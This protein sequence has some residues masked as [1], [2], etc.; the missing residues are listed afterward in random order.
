MKSSTVSQASPV[1]AVSVQPF[2]PTVGQ[3]PLCVDL[4]GTLV[5]TDTLWESLALLARRPRDLLRCP[6]WLLGGRAYFK[7]KVAEVTQ[8]NP[9]M[10]PY[11]KEVLSFLQE[12]REM[13]RKLILATAADERIARG[14]AEHL[15][16]FDAVICGNGVVN[17]KGKAK[18]EAIRQ[19]CP[20]GFDYIGDSMV[21]L[22]L[23]GRAEHAYLVAPTHRVLKRARALGRPVEV[24]AARENVVAALFRAIRPHQW[25]KNLLLLLPLILSHQ[26]TSLSK[27]LIVLLGIVAF[28]LCAS[29]VYVANDLL[30]LENDRRHMSKRCRPFASGRL[31]LSYGPPLVCLSLMLAASLS[32]ICLPWSFVPV[33]GL[34]AVTSMAYSLYLKRLLLLDTMAL[35]GLY[36]LRILAGGTA[37][38]VPVSSWLMAFSMFL[39]LSLAFAKRYTELISLERTA[40]TQKTQIQGRSYRVEDIRIIESVG[41]ASG[42]TA[43]LVLALYINSDVVGTLYADP[44]RLMLICPLLM[45]WITRLWFFARRGALDADPVLFALRDRVSWHVGLAIG[46]VFLFAWL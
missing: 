26:V 27:L 30:D 40:T 25:V 42:Y 45:Y 36:T 46:V 1:G 13:G 41:P 22:V 35:A 2:E 17:M 11:R 39:F 5:Q 24:L 6:L 3:I 33:L 19:M 7:R 15:G 4:D 16:I 38:G 20:E 43:V 10:L 29:A 18:L 31:P 34:Y 12:Q 9:T 14:V 23:W 8:V 21:D 32:V 37:A 28:N 44:F